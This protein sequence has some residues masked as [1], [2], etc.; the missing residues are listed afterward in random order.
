[1]RPIAVR[2][3]YRNIPTEHINPKRA[4]F[5]VKTFLKFFWPNITINSLKD[6]K[7]EVAIR[8]D[9]GVPKSKL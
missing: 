5:F 1:M 6:Q 7:R 8:T 9:L 4:L 3:M 2:A